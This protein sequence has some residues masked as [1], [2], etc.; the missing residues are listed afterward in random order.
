MTEATA[1][2]QPPAV[3][4]EDLILF[5]PNDPVAKKIDI[6][7]K[8]LVAPDR[9][10]RILS[11]LPRGVAFNFW[12]GSVRTAFTEDPSLLACTPTSIVKAVFNSAYVGL[13]P[14]RQLG[15]AAFVKYK[16]ELAYMPM[17]QGLVKLALMHPGIRDIQTGVVYD[18]DE[19]HYQRGTDPKIHHVPKRRSDGTPNIVAAY[20]IAWMTNGAV[21]F[22]VLELDDLESIRGCAATR[23][24]W[25]AWPGEM[26]RKS[27]FRRHRKWLPTSNELLRAIEVDSDDYAVTR[28][29]PSE[30]PESPRRTPTQQLEDELA[31]RAAAKKGAPPAGAGNREPGQDG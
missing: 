29:E 31:A 5:S 3:K 20:S 14:N 8:A 7:E 11:A 12:L 30:F 13:P 6:L 4:T 15:L 16:D 27:A 18:G 23:K 25:D 19:F 21:S 26:S 1:N 22:E 2:A 28:I 17:S 24:V 9:Q 10:A